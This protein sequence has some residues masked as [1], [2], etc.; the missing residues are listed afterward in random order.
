MKLG[1]VGENDIIVFENPFD[2]KAVHSITRP[3]KWGRGDLNPHALRHWILS[4]GCLPI[5]ALPPAEILTKNRY[6]VNAG[7]SPVFDCLQI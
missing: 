6:A 1:R 4:P 3:E 7:I 2:K 5:P